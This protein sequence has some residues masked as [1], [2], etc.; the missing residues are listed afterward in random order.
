ML[1][2]V[3]EY[4]RAVIFR[5]GRLLSGGSRGP[6]WHCGGWQC[7]C[8]DNDVYYDD[9]DDYDYEDNDEYDYDDGDEK[10]FDISLVMMKSVHVLHQKTFVEWFIKE[11]RKTF[12]ASSEWRNF[13]KIRGMSFSCTLLNIEH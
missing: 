4:E 12:K 6:G 11:E 5:L 8:E 3:Q 10:H 9:N 13:M 7:D 2:V 1:Q